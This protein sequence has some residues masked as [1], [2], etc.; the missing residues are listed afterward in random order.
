MFHSQLGFASGV[1]WFT[2]PPGPPV[3]T[4]NTWLFQY[5]LLEIRYIGNG[6]DWGNIHFF[7]VVWGS[8]LQYIFLLGRLLLQIQVKVCE[9]LLPHAGHREQYIRLARH[10]SQVAWP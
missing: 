1:L 3:P 4:R 10:A 8:R 9:V 5:G 6:W 7:L 2:F